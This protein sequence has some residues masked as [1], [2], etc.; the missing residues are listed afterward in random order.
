MAGDK[1][2]DIAKLEQGHLVLL[3]GCVLNIRKFK[4]GII[5]SKATEIWV[6]AEYTLMS[7]VQC[8]RHTCILQN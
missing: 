5:S 3:E 6:W 7:D 8:Q 4:K 2:P 1:D